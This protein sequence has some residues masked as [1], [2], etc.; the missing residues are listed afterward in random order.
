MALSLPHTL[1]ALLFAAGDALP[2]K[3]I[4]SMLSISE[5]MLAA[6]V[7]ELS[8]ELSKTGLAL[9]QTDSELELRTSAEAAPVVEEFRKNELSRDLGKAGLETLAIIL[10]QQGATRSEIDWIRGVNSTAALRSLLLR[11]LIER[12]AD[13]EDKRRMRYTPT[14]DTYAHLGVS[15]VTELPNV[16]ALRAQLSEHAATGEQGTVEPAE[17]AG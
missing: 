14:V 15:G 3:R 1:E 11:G 13:S 9:I 2:K 7:G 16:E 5:E 4:L 17:A 12:Q 8:E 6:A 10:Y